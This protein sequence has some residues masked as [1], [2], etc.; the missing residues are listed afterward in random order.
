MIKSHPLLIVGTGAMASLFAAR[1]RAV[2]IPV[3][4]IGSWR[5]GLEALEKNGVRLLEVDGR[6]FEYR[7]QVTSDP[8]ECSGTELALVLVKSYQTARAARQL[9]EC[10]APQGLALTLQN[11]LDNKAILEDELGPARVASGV[12]TMGATLIRPGIVRNGGEGIISIGDHPRLQPMYSLLKRAGFD[13]NIVP[14]TESLVWGKLVVNAAINPLTALLKVPNG[15][16]L[17]RLETRELLRALTNETVRVAQAKGIRLPFDRPV[18]Y[19][20]HVA[21]RT[22]SNYSSMLNDVLRG[23]PTEIDSIN[24]AVVRLGEAWGITA[25]VNLVMWRL[26]KAL[27]PAD[28]A[29]QD[30]P[31]RQNLVERDLSAVAQLIE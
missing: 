6:K 12:T 16:L 10:L 3:K 17:E 1:L 4:M 2:E 5:E 30:F 13:V 18:E 24:G 28:G 8:Q 31:P 22:A 15:Y 14:D 21:R 23:S 7:V 11:G 19:V 25:L 29:I 9:A 20:E 26:V 27:E